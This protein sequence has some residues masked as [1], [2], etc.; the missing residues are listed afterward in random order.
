MRVSPINIV[1]LAR[2]L[3]VV[4]MMS[5]FLTTYITTCAHIRKPACVLTLGGWGKSNRCYRLLAKYMHRWSAHPSTL[6]YLLFDARP[7]YSHVACWMSQRKWISAT[8]TTT[9]IPDVQL[10]RDV[11]TAVFMLLKL[12]VLMLLLRQT[13]SNVHYYRIRLPYGLICARLHACSLRNG[14]SALSRFIVN[15]AIISIL[16]RIKPI[17]SSRF[18]EDIS[19]VSHSIWI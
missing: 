8:S 6:Q 19:L 17:V 5:T 7:V 1:N 2:P 4:Y 11:H 13:S 3:F 10:W 16:V 9:T 14:I 15:I 18:Q 12:I